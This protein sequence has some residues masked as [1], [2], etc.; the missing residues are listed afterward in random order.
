MQILQ[1]L[2]PSGSSNGITPE[3]QS[4]GTSLLRFKGSQNLKHTDSMGSMGP[5]S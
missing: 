1:I 4:H 2:G 5:T 3:P